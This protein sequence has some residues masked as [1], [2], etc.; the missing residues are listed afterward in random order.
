M[1]SGRSTSA[2][3]NLVP[4]P[5]VLLLG[6]Y[7]LGEA[8]TNERLGLARFNADVGRLVSQ[9]GGVRLEPKPGSTSVHFRAAPAAGEAV[10][11]AVTQVA[12]RHGLLARAGRMV[13]EV[14][15]ARAQKEIALGHLIEELSP[16]AVVY[17]GDDTGDRGCFE[18]LAGLRLPHLAIGVASPEADRELFAGCDLV[19]EGPRELAPVLSRIADWAEADRRSG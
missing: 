14:T 13:V 4:V 11:T 16:Q 18:L 8:D 2:L 19:V 5:G 15:P 7:G 17:A 1:I 9:W 10:I 3:R 12:D 6:D